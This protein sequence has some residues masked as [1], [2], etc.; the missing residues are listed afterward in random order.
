LADFWFCRDGRRIIGL[1]PSGAVKQWELPLFRT[2]TDRVSSL[3]QLLTGQ[4]VDANDE[5]VPLDKSA[6]RSAPEQYRR[7]WISW[8]GLG[9]V[10]AVDKSVEFK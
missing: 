9:E 2:A 4:Q 3:V 10:A 1:A 7:A 5:I 6:F 8:R